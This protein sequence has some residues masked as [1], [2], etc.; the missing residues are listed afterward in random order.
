MPIRS[1]HELAVEE[2]FAAGGHAALVDGAV[3]HLA[4]S[5]VVL[6]AAR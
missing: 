6:T 4:S 2:G 5:K 1:F 3:H